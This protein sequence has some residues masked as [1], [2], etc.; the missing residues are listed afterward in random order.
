MALLAL[1]SD[2][3]K[4]LEYPVS[5]L[6][7]VLRVCDPGEP[8]EPGDSRYAD[9]SALRQGVGIGKLRRLLQDQSKSS[10]HQHCLCGHRGSGKSTELLSLKEWADN[11]GF[12]A[13][14]TEVDTEFGMIDLAFSDLF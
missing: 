6:G 5:D 13:V 10:Y 11:N 14:R 8:L 2:K 7:Q 12:L 1:G 4:A 3:E 9:F